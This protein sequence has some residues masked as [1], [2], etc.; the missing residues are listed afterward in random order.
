MSRKAVAGSNLGD[1]LLGLL[2]ER[3]TFVKKSEPSFLPALVVSQRQSDNCLLM[4]V[5]L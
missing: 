4:V 5:T 2:A 1:V 3:G